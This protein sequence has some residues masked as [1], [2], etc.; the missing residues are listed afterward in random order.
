MTAKI[1]VAILFA[2]ALGLSMPVHA[3]ETHKHSGQVS[4]LSDLTLNHGAKW[5]TDAPLRKG[6]NGILHDLTAVLPDIHEGKLSE[7]G[8]GA[9]AEKINGHLEYMFVNCKLPPAADEQLHLVLAEAMNGA[10]TM[11]AGPDRMAGAV[12]IVQALDAYGTHFDHPGWPG[13]RH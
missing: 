3:A 9:L 6:M 7:A 4:G 13:V 12:G 11:E 5:Q 1:H 2:A 8:Y 10:E